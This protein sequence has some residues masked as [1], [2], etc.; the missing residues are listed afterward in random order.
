M[1]PGLSGAYHLSDTG[2]LHAAV[3]GSRRDRDAVAGTGAGRG[4]DAALRRELYFFTL[5]RVLVAALMVLVAF[6]PVSVPLATLV[7]PAM[8]KAVSL[9]YLVTALALLLAGRRPAAALTW[10]AG[11]GLTLDI[12]ATLLMVHAVREIDIESCGKS[13][14]PLNGLVTQLHTANLL[15]LYD[16]LKA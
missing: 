5:Y 10:Q 15:A 3:N 7:L 16:R 4:S 1:F 12:I 8:A 13:R 9:V 6:S 11:I 14:I 2:R